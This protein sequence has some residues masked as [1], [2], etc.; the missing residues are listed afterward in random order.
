MLSTLDYINDATT[1]YESLKDNKFSILSK[2]Q[3]VCIFC[4]LIAEKLLLAIITMHGG[5]VQKCSILELLN[6]VM[7]KEYYFS[8]ITEEVTF[9]NVYSGCDTAVIECTV[10]DANT[11]LVY[12]TRIVE[13]VDRVLER[14]SVGNL[15]QRS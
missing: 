15:V 12:M 10:N 6:K 2:P 3:R 4:N 5:V 14:N 11:S 1:A 9:L 7:E 8:D 13:F